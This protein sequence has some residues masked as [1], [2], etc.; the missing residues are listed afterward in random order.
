MKGNLAEGI[1]YLTLFTA[2]STNNTVNDNLKLG[3]SYG[4]IGLKL[5][6]INIHAGLINDGFARSM[7]S[8]SAQLFGDYNQIGK[9]LKFDN[10]KVGLKVFTS[11]L[12]KKIHLTL[13]FANSP[14]LGKNLGDT[15]PG[16]I[17]NFNLNGADNYMIGFRMQF[18]PIGEWKEGKEWLQTSDMKL[19]IGLGFAVI[20]KMGNKTIAFA[21]GNTQLRLVADV[22]FTVSLFYI[23]VDYFINYKYVSEGFYDGVESN[24]ESDMGLKLDLAASLVDMVPG[25]D[26]VPALRFEWLDNEA[27]TSDDFMR[28]S[29]AV[30]LYPG[31]L[32]NKFRIT[33]EVGFDLT[34][35]TNAKKESFFRM[36][37]MLNF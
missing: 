33:P 31:N 32:G 19:T 36:N 3:V 5:G 34:R 25:L 2:K 11:L 24:K 22:G 30:N 18:D 37:F 26:I 15:D 29:L 9:S 23:S 27:L 17:Q 14:E 16:D 28:L 7:T 8:S 12:D 4:W 20:P 10:K 6:P 1:S 21:D 13:I 35:E